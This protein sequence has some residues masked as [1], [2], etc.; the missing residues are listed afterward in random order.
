MI[1]LDASAAI[2]IANDTLRGLAMR[3]LIESGEEVH[4]CELMQAEVTN[5][6]LKYVNAGIMDLREARARA[7]VAVGIVDAFHG[8]EP[9]NREVLAE[10]CRLK[11]P[12]Y[13]I[14]YLV[15]ARRL[16]ATLFTFDKKLNAL[17]DDCGVE[18]VQDVSL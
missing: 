10:A 12:A 3:K 7:D 4:S 9:L 13:D 15:L 5:A 18:R 6:Y 17:C 14:Y 2:E 16:G 8:F 11:H 1:V